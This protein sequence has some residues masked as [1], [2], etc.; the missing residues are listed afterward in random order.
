MM[1]RLRQYGFLRTEAGGILSSPLYFETV[2][3]AM[4]MFFFF[5]RFTISLSFSG[6]FGSSSVIVFWMRFL[7]EM[8]DRVSP[9]MLD[10]PPAKKNLSSYMPIGVCM[11]LFVVTRLIVDS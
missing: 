6:F 8:D 1:R 9:S 10:M 2:R 7:T 3:L 11:Y 4:S 5:S